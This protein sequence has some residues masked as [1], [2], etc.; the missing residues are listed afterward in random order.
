MA[1]RILSRPHVTIS[2][3]RCSFSLGPGFETLLPM[4]ISFERFSFSP[5]PGFETASDDYFKFSTNLWVTSNTASVVQ[6]WH[7]AWKSPSAT[8]LLCFC[9]TV[10]TKITSVTSQF[11]ARFMKCTTSLTQSHTLSLSVLTCFWRKSI[12]LHPCFM[13]IYVL[14]LV[15]LFHC[16]ASLNLKRPS[17]IV[18]GL[19]IRFT[20]K[21]W[22]AL[23]V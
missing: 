3:D 17:I 12:R 4:T 2:F 6:W 9:L 23:S 22:F 16:L 19:L 11:H 20:R 7:M 13:H 14:K 8:H 21:S 10:R 15:V 1:D 18:H 5:G